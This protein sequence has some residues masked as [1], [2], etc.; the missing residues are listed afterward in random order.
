MAASIDYGTA[1]I[2]QYNG[3]SITPIPVNIVQKLSPQQSLDIECN[4][5]PKSVLANRTANI[6]LDSGTAEIEVSLA[7]YSLNE[8]FRSGNIKGVLVPKVTP[9]GGENPNTAITEATCFVYNFPSFYGMPFKEIRMP[10]ATNVTLGGVAR[11]YVD[12]WCVDIAPVDKIEE[13][14]AQSLSDGVLYASHSVR[15]THAHD[16]DVFTVGDLLKILKYLR[17]FF[18]FIRGS[19]VGLSTVRAF[20]SHTQLKLVARWGMEHAA[21]FTSRSMLLSHINTGSDMAD[22]FSGY[23]PH[24]SGSN[25]DVI[26][27]AID[28]YINANAALYTLGITM[29][30]SALEGLTGLFVP[31]RKWKQLGGFRKALES[32]LGPRK[33]PL[34][35]P[36]QL[37]YLMSF[38]QQL[39]LDNGV[40]SFVKARNFIVHANRQQL[41]PLVFLDASELGQ[42]YVE[43][44]LLN[45]FGY[46]GRYQSRLIRDHAGSPFVKVP[47]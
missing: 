41:D 43:M 2:I 20:N 47:W 12:H 39:N 7:S 32:N 30:Q 18:S 21:P 13:L 33:I 16:Q 17:A 28:A 26:T 45:L 8:H 36:P 29:T 9:C 46:S 35:V 40:H 25:G 6:I 10:A 31:P 4:D 15:I 1:S 14:Q 24:V 38:R 42:W 23:F 11:L 44:L 5:L 19:D 22:I 27:Q 3:K 34:Y 37:S